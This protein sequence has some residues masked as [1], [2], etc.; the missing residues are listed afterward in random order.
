MVAEHAEADILSGLEIENDML[1]ALLR[2][3]IGKFDVAAG[4]FG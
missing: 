1:F 4:I 3:R 2:R